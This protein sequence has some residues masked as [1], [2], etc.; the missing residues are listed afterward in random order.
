MAWERSTRHD[1]LPDNWGE[2]RA[3]CRH[4][5]QG[6][7]QA[8]VHDPDCT[9]VGVECDHINQGDD[10]SLANLQWLSTPCHARKTR[11]DNEA[12]KKLTLPAERHPIRDLIEGR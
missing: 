1:R 2:L 6:R 3:S 11:L 8:L 4:N 12:G 7:C 9:G 5:A 10:H